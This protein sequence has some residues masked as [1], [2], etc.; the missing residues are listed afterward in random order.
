MQNILSSNTKRMVGMAILAAIVVNLQVVTTFVR[1]GTFSITLALT[2]I[3]VGAAMFGPAAGA[4]LGG[5]FGAVVLVGC[6]TGVDMGG[7]ILWSANPALTAALCIAK[8][9]AAGFTAGLV[10]HYIKKINAF[11][12]VVGSAIICPV[13]NTGIFI[14]AMYFL[15]HDTL[16]AWTDGWSAGGDVLYYAFIIMAGSNFLLELTVNLILSPGVMRIISAVERKK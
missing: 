6:I 14:A 2:P 16:T 9:A 12:G 11:A 5:V 7:F 10:Y 13:V 4:V 15:F 8:G 3:T 1:F